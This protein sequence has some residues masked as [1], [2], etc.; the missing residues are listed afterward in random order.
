MN[1]YI[2][3]YFMEKI[4]SKCGTEVKDY[5][6]VQSIIDYQYFETQVHF[7]RQLFG[8]FVFFFLPFLLQ[9]FTERLFVELVCLCTCLAV[10]LIL[11]SE[12]IIK[13]KY[14]GIYYFFN[15]WSLNNIMMF[16]LFVI[17]FFVKISAVYN[18]SSEESI[19]S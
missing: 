19:S 17:Y 10:S 12:E 11:F 3:S 5:R 9:I 2:V 15:V 13:M 8:F 14:T 18:S 16:I 7:V 1:N 4:V 6:V